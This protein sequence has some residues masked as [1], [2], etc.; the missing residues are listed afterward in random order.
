MTPAQ[1]RILFPACQAPGAFAGPLA[2]AMDCFEINT[3]A[4]QAAFLAQVGHE[5]AQLNRTSENL[6]YSAEGLMRTWPT[7]FIGLSVAMK[8]AYKP[9]AIANCVYANRMHNGDEQSGDG[10][11]YRGAG[12]I[13]LT[14]KENHLAA[15]LYFDK[16]LD[17]IS[18]WLRSPEGACMSAAWFWKC[19]GC[20]EAADEGDF[21]KVCDLIN[22]GRKTKAQGDAIGYAERLALFKQAEKVLA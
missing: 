8:Y 3:P 11:K 6:N 5:S 22:I 16:D 7:R 12:L 9:E 19:A 14:G 17:T 10:W 4:R 2:E 1:L 18:D 13:Q 20:N 15:S 21:D